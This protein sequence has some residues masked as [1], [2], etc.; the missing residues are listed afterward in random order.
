MAFHPRGRLGMKCWSLGIAAPNNCLKVRGAA[1]QDP[2]EPPH[3]TPYT[4][5]PVPDEP[6]IA[7]HRARLSSL[8]LHP[9][10]PPLA[11]D[12]DRW[13]QQA[14]TPWDAYPDT[15]S[16][17]FDAETAPLAHALKH[18]AVSL[19]TGVQV[20]RLLPSP[21]GKRIVALDLV[22]C[23]AGGSG[24]SCST[25]GRRGEF[26]GTAAAFRQYREQLQV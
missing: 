1:G 24:P 21:D 4:S 3:S 22:A 5:T 26:G 15:H 13:L 19:H 10:S 20:M 9:F 11:V 6:A 16:G 12:V 18:N 7:A 17:K 2:T 14:P 25:L 8:G 23:P